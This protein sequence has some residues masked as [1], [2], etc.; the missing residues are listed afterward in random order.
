MN[1]EAKKQEILEAFQFRHATKEFDPEKKISDE[2]FEFILETGRLSP[3]SFGF[4]PWRFVVIQD[5]EL[6]EQLKPVSWGAQKQLPTASHYIVMLARTAEDMMYDSEYIEHIKKDVKNLPKEAYDAISGFYKT[7]LESDFKLLGNDRAMV[8]WA[9]KQVYIALG[10]M[11]TA[12]AQIGI[13]SCPI[14]GFDQEKVQAILE[15]EGVLQGGNFEVAVMVGFGY[16]V[17]EPRP[18]VR[19]DMSDVVKWIE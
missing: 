7:F 9:A 14:E 12:A 5:P 19:Q 18:K 2:D 4:E 13:D 17:N 1:K 6:R 8:D 11:M 10:N 16:R 15:R 3:S